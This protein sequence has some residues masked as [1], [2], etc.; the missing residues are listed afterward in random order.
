[1]IGWIISGIFIVIFIIYFIASS[2]NILDDGVVTYYVDPYPVMK[3]AERNI[4]DAIDEAFAEWSE[5]NPDLVF[6][7]VYSANE[8]EI[9]IHW[10]EKVYV[11]GVKVAGSTEIVGKYSDITI[12]YGGLDCNSKEIL[13]TPDTIKDILK[14]EIG[15]VLGLV[16]SSDVNHLMYDPLDMFD[17]FDNLGYVIPDTVEY[18][19]FIGEEELFDEYESIPYQTSRTDQL[20]KEMDCIRGFKIT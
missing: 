12:D 6:E 18:D 13:Y 9:K 3:N 5:L 19:Y 14:H 2:G 17:N 8:S 4:G 16:H 10:E 20:K 7:Q 11:N 1:M 15:H